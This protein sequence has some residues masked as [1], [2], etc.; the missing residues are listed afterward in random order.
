MGFKTNELSGPL[1][2]VRTPREKLSRIT[3]A[4][5][6]FWSSA[7]ERGV[8]CVARAYPSSKVSTRR[9]SHILHPGS[10]TFLRSGPKQR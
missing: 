8:W 10:S 9:H 3:I 1:S 4:D 7:Q 6:R 2:H 5:G